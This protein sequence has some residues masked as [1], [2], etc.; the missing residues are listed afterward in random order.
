MAI[1]LTKR[2][3]DAAEAGPER[4]MLW[5]IEIKGF[6][7]LVLPSGVKSFIYDYRD[8]QGRKRRITIG[9]FGEWTADEARKKADKLHRIR[10]DG[11]DP[12]AE[13]K[14]ERAA[15]TIGEVFDIYL[16][17]DAFKAKAESTQKIDRGRIARH[18]RPLLGKVYADKLSRAQVLAARNDIRDGK[19]AKRVRTK[20]RGLA[21][22]TG[23]ET[24]ARD[25]IALLRAILN[26]AVEAE[27]IAVSRN[28]AADIKLGSHRKRSTILEGAEDYKRLFQTLDKME[29]ERRLRQP[30]A[31]AIRVIALTGARRG[32]IAGLRWRHV[33]MRGARIVLPPHEHKTGEATNEDRIIGLPAVAQEIIARQPEGDT[34]DFVFKPA[35]GEGAI[36]LS[37]PWRK[38]RTEAELPEGIGLHGLRH[39]VASHLAMAGAGAAEI[40][41]AV[42]HR[43]MS[44]TTRYIHWA[45]QQRSKLAEKAA[46]VAVAGMATVSGDDGAVVAP[47]KGVRK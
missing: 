11:G 17:S 20:A 41:A 21:R 19:T 29:A 16:E 22:V 35:K 32:E 5:D 26:W 6:G 12:L 8:A 7:L 42:G 15:L 33:D 27:E 40:M 45:E 36:N 30:V 39:S 38:I 37:A 28:A 24:T 46:A 18:L 1:K 9:K 31:D 43:Q 2:P 13:R 25:T 4:Y 44:T 3:V 14:A 34:D 23:G 47:I 10:K